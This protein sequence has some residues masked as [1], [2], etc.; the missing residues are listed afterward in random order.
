MGARTDSKRSW[1]SEALGLGIKI[2]VSVA[3]LYLLSRA[4]SFEAVGDVLAD[5]RPLPL[6]AAIAL[7]FAAQIPFAFRLARVVS[8]L[9]TPLS[10]RRALE[11]TFISHS[12][13]Q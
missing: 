11:L 1:P 6:V 12:M 5:I 8:A 10:F 13:S 9:G 4:V 7:I 2:I 3:V